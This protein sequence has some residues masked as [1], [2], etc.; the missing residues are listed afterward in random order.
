M[1]VLKYLKEFGIGKLVSE[2]SIKVK[3]YE[4]GLIVLGYDQ[5]ESPKA[6]SIVMECRGLILDN[7]YNVVSRGFDRFFNYGEQPQ[8]QWHI[9]WKKAVCFEKV[10]GSLIKIYWWNGTWYVSTRGT[11]FAESSV[12]GFNVTFKDLVFKALNVADDKEFQVRCET[13]LDQQYTYVFE[14]TATE[15]RVVKVYEGYTLH[16]LG[17]RNNKTFEYAD[18]GSG[19]NAWWDAKMLGAR[20]INCY[21]FDSPEACLETAT[22]LKDLDEGYVLWQEGRPVCKIKSPAYVAVH[23]IRGEGLN[24]KRISQIVLTGETDEYLKYFPEDEQHFLPYIDAHKNLVVALAQAYE[25]TYRIDDQKEFALRVKDLPFSAILFTC[26]K[27]RKFP[28]TVF[29]EAREDYKI[30][31]LGEFI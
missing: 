29:N 9:D 3:E 28:V 21:R 15:N 26:K 8:T 2:F 27:T 20:M 14:I 19:Y 30:K 10:D 24:P 7:D 18:F 1:E 22:H 16:Y 13:Y 11:A 31:L 23:H 25:Q 12:N 4:E 5:I 6:H 17:A